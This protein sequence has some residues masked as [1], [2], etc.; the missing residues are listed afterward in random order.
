VKAVEGV[1]VRWKALLL[2]SA[3]AVVAAVAC[4]SGAQVPKDVELPVIQ[5]TVSGA[6]CLN[7]RYPPDAPQFG[8]NSV[9]P[10]VPRPSGLKVFDRVVGS[11]GTPPAGSF[12]TVHY[13]GWL[14]DGC[15]FDSSH[16]AGTPGDFPL[17]GLISG[18]A[19]GVSS[20]Q[21]G[22]K[23]RL[24]IP[25]DLAYGTVG[26]PGVIPPNATLVFEIELVSFADAAPTPEPEAAPNATPTP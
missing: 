3:V 19:E 11:G 8:D 10:Y 24:E 20:M 18:W 22:G 14:E 12:V 4:R 1:A 21:A 13:T 17:E 2:V 7:D 15:I 16:M 6:A 9:I 26:F 23:R 25:S 5:P